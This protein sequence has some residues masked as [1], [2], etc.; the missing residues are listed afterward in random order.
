MSRSNASSTSA[1]VR[2]ETHP[3][4]PVRGRWRKVM[5]GAG[6]THT[7]AL[8]DADGRREATVF[9]DGTWTAHVSDV[10][11]GDGGRFAHRGV[12]LISAVARG[13]CLNLATRAQGQI[14]SM[15]EVEDMLARYAPGWGGS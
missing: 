15:I 13:L 2:A 9:A 3:G 5:D 7:V 6:W 10:V 11:V 4:E 8:Y 12:T 14:E 1:D